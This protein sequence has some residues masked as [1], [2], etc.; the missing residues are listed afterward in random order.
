MM[1]KM[2]QIATACVSD[3][4]TAR[5]CMLYVQ[6]FLEN[7]I[8]EEPSEEIRIEMGE[9]SGTKDIYSR[10]KF[11]INCKICRMNLE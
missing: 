7:V 3:N 8:V 4:P 1:L 6:E 11:E 2:L 5:P 10:G 9:S